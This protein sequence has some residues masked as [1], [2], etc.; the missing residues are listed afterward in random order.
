[1]IVKRGNSYGVRVYVDGRR[2]WVGTFK[3]RREAREAEL[4]ALRRPPSPSEETCD[5]F[6]ARWVDD[7]PRP[8]AATRHTHTYALRAFI[9]D[10]TGVR[11]SEVDRPTARAWAG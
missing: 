2:K 8:A 3:T 7:Y 10:F 5:S 4:E 6:A 11:L 1:V 9:R